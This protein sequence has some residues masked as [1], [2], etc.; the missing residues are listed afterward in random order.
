MTQ[1]APSISIAGPDLPNLP[2]EDRPAGSSA[3]V[4]RYSG[5]PIIPHDLI[6]TSNSIFNSAVVPYG[7]GFAG[8]FRVDD[9]RRAMQLHA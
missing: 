3:V 4:W 2:W 7:E 6:P 9:T 8:V 5:N 1:A